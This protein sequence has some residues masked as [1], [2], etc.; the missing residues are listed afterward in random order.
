MSK[1]TTFKGKLVTVRHVYEEKAMR[2]IIKETRNKIFY[3]LKRYRALRM[4]KLY[5]PN[6]NERYLN[7]GGGNWYYPR[8]ENIDLYADDIFVDYRIDLRLKQ[9]IP[10]SDSCAVII[11][12]SHVLE[13]MSDED[14]FFVLRE[15][16]RIL[17]PEGILRIVIRDMDKALEAYRARDDRFFDEGGALCIGDSIERKLVNFFA[18]YAKDGYRG[19]PIVSPELVREKLRALDKYQFI[20]WCAGLIPEDAPY[21]AHVNG[22]DFAKL[23]KFIK[24]VGFRKVVKSEHRKSSAKI[25]REKAFDN[26]PVVSLFVDVFK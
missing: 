9:P 4:K 10:V 7:I 17:K 1:A 12:S 24:E 21:K 22:Y 3:L 2:G 16:Y 6:R 5:P 11:F 13:H 18:S 19:G 8:W 26:C 15:C 14:C 23:K 25:L 20:T